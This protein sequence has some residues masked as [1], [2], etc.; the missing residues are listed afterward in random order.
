[1]SG[2]RAA[3]VS[4]RAPSFSVLHGW[5]AVKDSPADTSSTSPAAATT[6]AA[7]DA[8]LTIRWVRLDMDPLI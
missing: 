3:V 1:M 7:M 2:A 4:S 8:L 5:S 6:Y